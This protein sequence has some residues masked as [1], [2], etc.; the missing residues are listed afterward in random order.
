VA[1]TN[2]SGSISHLVGS[3]GRAKMSFG[4]CP[5][6]RGFYQPSQQQ[7]RITFGES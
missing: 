6:R 5:S 7:G 4:F 1:G 3:V 2:R